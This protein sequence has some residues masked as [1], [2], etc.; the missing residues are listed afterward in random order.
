MYSFQ[1]HTFNAE[2]LFYTCLLLDFSFS[3]FKI[4]VGRVH[5]EDQRP[6][7]NGDFIFILAN[8]WVRLDEGYR[9]RN[10]ERDCFRSVFST[11]VAEETI[12]QGG[13]AV[14]DT[15]LFR[16]VEA[17]KEYF[18]PARDSKEKIY[19]H[20]LGIFKRYIDLACPRP[21][22]LNDDCD[23]FSPSFDLRATIDVQDHRN[24]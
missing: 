4:V 24:C 19:F 12:F 22:R 21:P 14:G 17:W 18:C 5:G 23:I 1:L 6:A 16:L 9:E 20:V 2:S 7:S 10:C 15:L 3:E 8:K 13:I 11:G